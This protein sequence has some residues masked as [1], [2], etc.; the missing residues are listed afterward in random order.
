VA[1]AAPRRG[2]TGHMPPA[3]NDVP[4]PGCAQ[5]GELR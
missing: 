1:M 4:S 5:A 3:I 2:Q